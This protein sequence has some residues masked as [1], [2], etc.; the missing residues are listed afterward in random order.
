M[1]EMAERCK[2]HAIRPRQSKDGMP[3]GDWKRTRADE[4]AMSDGIPTV[5]LT[6]RV[7]QRGVPEVVRSG[8][9]RPGGGRECTGDLPQ[10]TNQRFIHAIS[11]KCVLIVRLHG[12]HLADADR[13][14]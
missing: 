6:S 12:T 11:M 14:K 1:P 13:A 3:F 2:R 5:T 4:Q 10:L 9:A 8:S 7:H